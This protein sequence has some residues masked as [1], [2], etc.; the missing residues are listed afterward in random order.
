MCNKSSVKMF[1]LL[2][3]TPG[4]TSLQFDESVEIKTRARDRRIGVAKFAF[5]SLILITNTFLL[6]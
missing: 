6:A 4:V 2:S 1:G 5:I 3:E